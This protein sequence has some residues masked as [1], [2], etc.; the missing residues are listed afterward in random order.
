MRNSSNYDIHHLYLAPSNQTQW[1]PDQLGTN[2]MTKNGGTFTLTGIPCGNYDLKLVDEGGD[3]CIVEDVRIC[4]NQA[5]DI[6]NDNLLRC[7]GWE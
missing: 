6:S 2:V 4:E 5:V 7:Q 3:E 1:G